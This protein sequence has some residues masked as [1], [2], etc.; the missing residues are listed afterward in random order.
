MHLYMLAVIVST[1][2]VNKIYVVVLCNI[3][4]QIAYTDV[5]NYTVYSLVLYIYTAISIG[6]TRPFR[7]LSPQPSEQSTGA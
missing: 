5:N 7:N 2:N 4:S 6:C 1:I 3:R